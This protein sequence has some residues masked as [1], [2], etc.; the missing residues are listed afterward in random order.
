MNNELKIKKC[1]AFAGMLLLFSCNKN[2]TPTSSERH[3]IKAKIVEYGTDNPIAGAAISVWTNPGGKINTIT[4]KN[5]ECALEGDE[6]A[7]RSFSKEGYWDY[8]FSEKQFSP[9]ILFPGNSNINTR[10]GS[11]YDCES[12]VLKLIPK[13]YITLH[14]KDSLVL[15]TCLDCNVFVN[16]NAKFT[17]NGNSYTVYDTTDINKIKGSVFLRRKIDTT[18]QIAIFGNTVNTF[19]IAED[20]GVDGFGN[21][22]LLQQQMKLIPE[23][24]P[25]F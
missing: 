22:R 2:K 15:S 21:Y 1:I 23:K 17:Q 9:L 16:V 4:D 19:N 8:N 18:F 13:S 20:D 14:I 10:T 24:V 11:V 6:I 12:F 7:F 3:I 25:F 5:G